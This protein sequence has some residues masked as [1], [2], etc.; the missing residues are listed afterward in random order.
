[1]SVDE[2]SRPNSQLVLYKSVFESSFLRTTGEY[3][4]QKASDYISKLTC[5]E[6][7][8]KVSI[9]IPAHAWIYYIIYHFV[10]DSTQQLFY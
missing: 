8:E 10:Q 9:A 4:K 7:L 5:C 3:Y 6:Y 2:Q 1:V